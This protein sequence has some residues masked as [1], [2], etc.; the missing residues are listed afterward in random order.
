MRLRILDILTAA[1]ILAMIVA[2]LYIWHRT[3]QEFSL[4]PSR[5][6]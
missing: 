2:I 4:F 6:D 5:D 1:L 3:L